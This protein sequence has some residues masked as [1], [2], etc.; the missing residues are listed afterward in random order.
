MTR[1]V[2]AVVIT[3]IFISSGHNFF[4]HHGRAPGRHAARAVER[5]VCHAG[6]GLAGDRFYDYRP[7][8]SG[9][10]TF[11]DWAVLLAARRELGVPELAADAFRRNVVVSGLDLPALV[12][13]SFR[14]QGVLF[15][16]VAE[17]K[18]CYW[19]NDA[20]APGAEQWLRGS[21]GL[22]ARIRSDGELSVG[23]VPDFAVRGETAELPL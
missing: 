18:P 19:M 22:R 7:D 21:G 10:V 13:R 2:P 15:E 17:A 14:L 20:V 12:G 9:Q 3:H 8:Y 1:G 23:P 5:V 6:R 11:F 4:G 16:G